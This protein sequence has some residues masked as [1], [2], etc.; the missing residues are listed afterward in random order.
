MA[1]AMNDNETSTGLSV[2]SPPV[3]RESMRRYL[4]KV[5]GVEISDETLAAL[6]D[7]QA[8]AVFDWMDSFPEDPALAGEWESRVPEFMEYTIDPDGPD[9]IALKSESAADH[10][11]PEI[12]D[13]ESEPAAKSP[14][15]LAT[16]VVNKTADVELQ[17][18]NQRLMKERKLIGDANDLVKRKQSERDIAD[19][20]VAEAKGAAKKKQGELD[21]AV[22]E[23]SR[24]ISDMKAGQNQLPFDD[25]PRSTETSPKNDETSKNPSSPGTLDVKSEPIYPLDS[26]GSKAMKELVGAEDFDR[27]K[28]EEDP[29]GLSDKV[30]EKLAHSA[31]DELKSVQ[32]LEAWMR[33]DAYW[34]QKI[35]GCGE[36]GIQRI[37]S[38]LA[39]FRRA[40]PMPAEGA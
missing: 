20:K 14:E 7:E 33:A 18:E 17:K 1:T 19:A 31:K 15:I 30:L 16:N 8:E 24:I 13:A 37:V 25:V 35:S 9:F 39:A 10:A 12:L 2:V 5:S 27:A 3:N 11:D 28:D 26:L 38:T 29:I 34:H 4:Q 21:K 22:A 40:R 32:D 6:T 23:L 36:R